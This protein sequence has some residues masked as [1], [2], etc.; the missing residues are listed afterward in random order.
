MSNGDNQNIS[1]GEAATS[2]LTRLSPWEKEASQQEVYRFVRWYGAGRSLAGLTAPEIAS[3]AEQ[4]SSSDTDYARKLELVRAF[5]AHAKKAGWSKT[6][7]AVH[8]K[9]RRKTGLPA[10][11]KQGLPEAISLT[12]EGYT[13]LKQELAALK[14][15]RHEVIDEMR[16]AAA[17]KD[18]RENAPLH[19]ARERR[20]HLEGRIKELEETLKLATVISSDPKSSARASIGDSVLLTDLASGEELRYMIV[21][22]RET[23]PIKG[24]ISSQSP[25]GKAI[26]GHFEGQVVEVAAPAGKR[27]YRINRV[28]H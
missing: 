8:L 4:L 17:D 20:G 2:F 14:G 11:A 21:N 28:E 19:A 10:P 27:Q 1:L 22:P 25:I 15:Q 18:F 23:D 24:K 12:E 3:Y 6:N 9:T 7:L 16:R 26:V 13:G 5:L